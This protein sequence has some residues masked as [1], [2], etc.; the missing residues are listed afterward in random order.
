MLSQRGNVWQ[1]SNT[2]IC[3]D[4]KSN[5]ITSLEFQSKL[6]ILN[7][8]IYPFVAVAFWIYLVVTTETILSRNHVATESNAWSFGQ[9]VAIILIILPLMDFLSVIKKLS[10]NGR[11]VA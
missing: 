9:T 10:Q 6:G 3:W 8:V 4:I 7:L 2:W 5:S 1:V 11:N